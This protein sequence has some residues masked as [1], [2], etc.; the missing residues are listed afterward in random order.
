MIE[1]PKVLDAPAQQTAYIH[2]AVPRSEIQT[3]MGPGITEIFEALGAQGI[4][5]TGP[6]FT[7][8]LKRPD[9]TFDFN[10]CVPVAS[11]VVPVG[12]VKVGKVPASTVARTVYHGGYEGLGEAWGEFLQWIESQGHE[13]A[14]D[15]WEC[16]LAGPESG[17]DPSQWR[18]QLNRPLVAVK[19]L[20]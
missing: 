18:T 2:I 9:E 7:H 13:S 11:P 19:Q 8:H 16:Y 20:K 14:E 17:P 12:R 15:L 5:S 1:A 10:I 6:W 4:K 3:V